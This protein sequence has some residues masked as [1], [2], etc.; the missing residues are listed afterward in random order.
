MTNDDLKAVIAA[1]KAGIQKTPVKVYDN[2]GDEITF[3]KEDVVNVIGDKD[4][5]P[6]TRIILANGCSARCLNNELKVVDLSRVLV[7]GTE[8]KWK[9]LLDFNVVC[10][11]DPEED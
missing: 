11:N 10:L 9:K 4:K 3:F 2:E 7:F 1:V 5:K 6:I 8:K